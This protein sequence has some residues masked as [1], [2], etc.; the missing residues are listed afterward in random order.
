MAE[1]PENAEFITYL[2][3][4]QPDIENLVRKIAKT[5][6]IVTGFIL[7]EKPKSLVRFGNNG[8]MGN[9]L[10]QLHIALSTLAANLEENKVSYSGVAYADIGQGENRSAESPE[11]VAYQLAK[12]VL[13]SGM[14]PEHTAQA[15]AL[16]ERYIA[17]HKHGK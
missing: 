7:S 10:I 8:N 17:L 4:L 6:A 2:S 3:T 12:S 13:I 1:K 9:N 5:G 16:A 14:E 15:L 11:D